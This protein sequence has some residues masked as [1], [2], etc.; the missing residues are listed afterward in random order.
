[1]MEAMEFVAQSNMSENTRG[2]DA[3]RHNMYRPVHKGLRSLMCD[4]LGRVGRL[5]AD[6]AAETAETVGRVREML[7]LCR[8]HLHHEN[9]FIHPALEARCA[10][11]AVATAGDHVHHETALERLEGSLRQVERGAGEARRQAAQALYGELTLFVA[12]NFRHMQV[13]ETEN[14]AALWEA[15]ADEELEAIH[16]ALVASI[17]P[18]KMMVYLR[19]M[20]PA[21]APDER[22]ELLGGIRQKLPAEAFVG[23]LATVKPV[24]AL[25]DWSKLMVALGEL[26]MAA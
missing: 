20:V 12:E 11:S 19:W 26:P 4:M 13:E 22:A 8:S 10:G 2:A 21:M 18:E 17:P 23:V 24:L 25:R 9:Q 1:M 3:R 5:D 6:D 7:F 16:D 14:N 15:Y